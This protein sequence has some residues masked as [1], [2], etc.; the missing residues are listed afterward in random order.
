L[1]FEEGT[2]GRKIEA[3]DDSSKREKEG[4]GAV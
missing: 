1:K 2:R 3:R 4:E